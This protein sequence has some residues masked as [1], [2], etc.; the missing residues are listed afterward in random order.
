[1]IDNRSW[2]PTAAV[3]DAW[4]R[5][6]TGISLDFALALLAMAAALT[7]GLFLILRRWRKTY[8]TTFESYHHDD[9]LHAPEG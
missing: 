9:R 2:M 1:M 4:W 5:L 8:R 6:N 3:T 7:V